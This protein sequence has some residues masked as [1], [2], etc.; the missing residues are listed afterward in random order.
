MD[1]VTQMTYLQYG[2]QDSAA[3]PFTH[4]NAPNYDMGHGLQSRNDGPPPLPPDGLLG[5]LDGLSA[6]SA[7]GSI[8]GLSVSATGTGTTS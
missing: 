4:F 2:K 6:V 1:E 5:A 8:D 3:N 7:S